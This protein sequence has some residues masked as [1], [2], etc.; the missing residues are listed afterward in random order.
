MRTH[1]H[2][3]L[4][5]Q[6]LARG[7]ASKHGAAG[8]HAHTHHDHGKVEH[9]VGSEVTEVHNPPDRVRVGAHVDSLERYRD[10]HREVG[11]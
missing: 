9:K 5:T 2:A 1:A 11:D 8:S 4:Q 10:L 6:T 7:L 3:G